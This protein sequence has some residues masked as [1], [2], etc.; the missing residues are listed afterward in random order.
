MRTTFRSIEWAIPSH[1]VIEVDIADE[2]NTNC[3]ALNPKVQEEVIDELLTADA[4]TFS[5][6]PYILT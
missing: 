6:G 3:P 1:K 2:K 4:V 5:V